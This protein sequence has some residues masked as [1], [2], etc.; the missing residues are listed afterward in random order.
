M[1]GVQVL[2]QALQG[3]LTPSGVVCEAV[4]AGLEDTRDGEASDAQRKMLYEAGITGYLP[5]GRQAGRLLQ[6][7]TEAGY[8]PGKG[9]YERIIRESESADDVITATY[10]DLL[11]L[12]LEPAPETEVAAMS[13]FVDQASWARALEIFEDLR[14]TL[15]S[16][17]RAFRAFR[18]RPGGSLVLGPSGGPRKPW[19]SGGS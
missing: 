19:L 17:G 8:S 10:D 11:R 16:G 3:G 15:L 14:E 4:L 1:K 5:N 12:Q 18:A 6:Q 9:I 2:E 13:A 7:M